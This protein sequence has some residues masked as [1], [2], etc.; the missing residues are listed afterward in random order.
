MQ[1]ETTRFFE[2]KVLPFWCY[3][4]ENSYFNGDC[5]II[6]LY[7]IGANTETWQLTDLAASSNSISLFCQRW[8]SAKFSKMTDLPSWM[9]TGPLENEEHVNN[10]TGSRQRLLRHII[11]ELKLWSE[12]SGKKS[13]KSEYM[14][15]QTS[16][17]RLARWGFFCLFSSLLAMAASWFVN[18]LF[19]ML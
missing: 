4:N 9:S 16:C 11:D 3:H 5:F 1:L 19:L 7:F 8:G 2:G 13:R 17:N 18:F 15:D 14:G 6:N 12:W 10:K